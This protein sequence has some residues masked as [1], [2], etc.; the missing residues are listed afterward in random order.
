MISF[1]TTFSALDPRE[2]HMEES[3]K[4]VDQLKHNPGNTLVH[5]SRAGCGVSQQVCRILAL[6][7]FGDGG[8]GLG[9]HQCN[10][11]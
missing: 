8:L 9:E 10:S 1:S 3:D 5:S 2:W 7:I 4:A 6:N 11:K